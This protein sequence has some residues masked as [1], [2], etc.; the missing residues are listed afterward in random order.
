MKVLF[1]ILSGGK[2][3]R[4]RPVTF[5][6]QKT[7]LPASRGKRIIDYAIESSNI[8]N[9]SGVKGRTIVLARYKSHQ[10]VDYVN[11]KYPEVT[12]LTERE[13]FDT[14]GAI[15]QHWQVICEYGPKVVI[16]LN[17][18]HFVNLPLKLIM[19]GYKEKI[20]ALLVV[21]IRS[22]AEYHDYINVKFNSNKLLDRFHQRASDIA[23]TGISILRFDALKSCIENLSMGPCN[24]TKDI[25]EWIYEKHGGVY[26]ILENEWEDL[27]TWTRYIRFLSRKFIQGN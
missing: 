2:G 7:L 8:C 12:V 21:G 18:D 27:G 10:V 22:N 25:I 19:Q 1:I 17:G 15:L 14:G 13:S 9:I 4:L 23:Y 20:P 16:I 3:K 26:Y 6:K 5:F 24:V 11:K